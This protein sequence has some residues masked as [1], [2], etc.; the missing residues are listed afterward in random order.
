M[1]CCAA[2]RP[3]SAL[4]EHYAAVLADFR[5]APAYAG[6]GLVRNYNGWLL[7]VVPIER[8]LCG[9]L[10]GYILK[11]RPSAMGRVLQN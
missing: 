8:Q 9:T 6:N 4:R 5:A 10:R 1:P 3:V 2:L 7:L 11:G